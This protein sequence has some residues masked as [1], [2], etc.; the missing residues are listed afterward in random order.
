MA[1]ASASAMP[2]NIAGKTFPED[3]GFLP[4]ASMALKPISPIAIAGPK[5]P[6]AIT[7]PL[8]KIISKYVTPLG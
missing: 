6:M 5:P 7:A 3:S 1:I 4:I 8:A 2:I